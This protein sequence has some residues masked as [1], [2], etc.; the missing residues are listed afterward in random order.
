MN[1]KLKIA[2]LSICAVIIG[3]GV[4]FA[5]YNV[6]RSALDPDVQTLNYIISMYKKYYYEQTDDIVGVFEKALLDKYSQ[7]YTKEEYQIV[8]QTSQGIREGIGIS[9]N[10]I[11]NTITQVLGNSPAKKAGLVEGSKIIAIGEDKNNLTVVDTENTVD[12][13]L[14]AIPSYTDFY[15][16]TELD[17]RNVYKLAK[18][19]YTQTFVEYFDKSG[20][21]GFFGDSGK[22]AFDKIGEN[23]AYDLQDTQ[24]TAVIKYYGFNGLGKGL[25]GS[26]QQFKMALG[27]FKADGNTCLIIDLR[28][29]GGG[30]MNILADISSHLIDAPSGSKQLICYAKYK[31][32]KVSNQYSPSVDYSDYGFEKII[33]LANENSASASEALMGAVLDYDKTQIVNVILQKST[34]SGETVYK[35]YGKGIMQSTYT[36]VTG[37]AIKLTTAK[38][39]WPLSNTSIHGVGLTPSLDSR[40][41]AESEKGCVYDAVLLSK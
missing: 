13:L 12:S 27:K 1:K 6:G 36:R 8:K 15:I 11:E 19:Q 24:K 16:E 25:D 4:F 17:G 32:G 7:Y 23:T 14:N 3:V 34:L 33:F 40:I 5:G 29:N 28:N 35:S 38:I 22:I 39:Y 21:Y 18:Q 20:V 9:Y 37:E 31:D 26:A 30:Y 2:L 10:K 41:L